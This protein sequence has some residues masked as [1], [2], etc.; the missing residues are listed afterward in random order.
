MVFLNIYLVGVPLWGLGQPW[1][2]A[3]LRDLWSTELIL[4]IGVDM[5]EVILDR[6][7]LRLTSGMRSLVSWLEDVISRTEFE[8]KDSLRGELMELPF[9]KSTIFRFRFR[10]RMYKVKIDLVC[11]LILLLKSSHTLSLCVCRI[12]LT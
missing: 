5:A 7:L 11:Y 6:D 1:S 9:K 10:W 4:A 2:L 8:R 3:L 12:Y